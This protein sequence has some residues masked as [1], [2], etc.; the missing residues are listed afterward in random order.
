MDTI[1]TMLAIFVH[2]KWPVYQ[3]NVNSTFLN[4]H[5]EE[6]VYVEHPQGYEITGKENKV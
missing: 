5:L 2:N 3:M 6:E 1:R 4:G